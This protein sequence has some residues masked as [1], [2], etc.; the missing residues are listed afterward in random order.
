MH[1]LLAIPGH[2]RTVPMGRFSA[3]A[4]QRL[5]HTV[6]VFDYRRQALDKL[7]DGVRRWFGNIEESV[8]VMNARLRRL[9][10]A[11]RP[12]VFITIYGF[13]IAPETLAHLRRLNIP[14]ACWWINDPF[15]FQRSLK[16]AAHYDAVFTN[17][18]VCVADYL[19]HGVRA[20]AFLP[21]AF[22]PE[23]HRP[24][25]P[26]KEYAS[27]VCF[28]G[29]WSPLRE[30]LMR[31]LAGKFD[32]RIFGPWGKKLALDSP[33]RKHLVDGFF[34]PEDMAA[35]FCSAKLVLNIHTWHGKADHGLNP[36]L[37]EA[38]GCGAAQIVDWKQEIPE[39][40]DIEREL[41]VYRTLDEVGERI[42]SALNHPDSLAQLGPAARKKALSAHTYQHR[43]SRL[44]HVLGGGA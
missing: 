3:D 41:I 12:D 30:E 22:D 26:R 44:L 42:S 11:V 37:F 35:M 43:M 15:Q 24:V 29:D 19:A 13:Y 4:L 7:C 16:R 2:L 28:A 6:T 14:S 21:T 8:P 1:I 5:G 23:I 39:L 17:D 20:A 36:R 9:V 31:N 18:S 27:E 10:D 34:N 40:F 38:A 25:A 32:I 33:L